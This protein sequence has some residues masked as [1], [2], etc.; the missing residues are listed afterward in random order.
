VSAERS[1]RDLLRANRASLL[2][3]PA[4][5][6]LRARCAALAARPD[7]GSARE[8]TRFWRVGL[9]P[10]A[11]AASIVLVVG[12]VILFQATRSST[13]LLA[14]E[15]AADHVK[16]F[17]INAVLGTSE[18]R[19]AVERSLAAG[20]GWQAHLPERPEQE[21]LEL[22]GARPCL[23]PDGKIAHIM[24]RHKGR[25]VS[26]FMLPKE[27]RADEL[28]AVLGHEAAVWS[29]GDRTFV[30]VGREPREEIARVAAFVHAGLK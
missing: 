7:A 11:L 19:A 28:V 5:S 1:V 21:G 16:C 2:A 27:H 17:M 9:A 24:Y 15:L 26:V 29:D 12:A 14:A 8:G 20:F 10:I 22:V 30:V 23:Y 18:A 4:P 6:T 3:E 25:P 13:R